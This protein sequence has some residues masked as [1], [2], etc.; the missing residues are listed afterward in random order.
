MEIPVTEILDPLPRGGRGGRRAGAGRKS[1]EVEDRVAA[2]LE[3][4]GYVPLAKAR[5]RKESALA[6]K[7]ELEFKRMS[8]EYIER[9]AVREACATAYAALAQA[10]RSIPDNLERRAG[11]APEI[12]EQVGDV[13]DETLADLAAQFE[14]FA[15]PQDA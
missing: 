13:I 9:A 10:L 5:A 6:D 14:M 15:E 7:A 11:V 1:R 3:D 2:E 4:D 8:G 12:A